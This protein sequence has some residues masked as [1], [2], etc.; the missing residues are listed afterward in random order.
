MTGR[1]LL[2]WRHGRTSWN[3]ERRFQGHADVPLDDHGRTE[4]AAAATMLAAERPD[5]I[6]SSDLTRATQTAQ[7]L[8]ER[9]GL[10]VRLDARLRETGLGGWEG[11]TAPEIELAYPEEWRR[12]RAGETVRRGGGELREEVAA[13]ALAALA[14][15]DAEVVVLVTHGGTAKVLAASLLDL[16][17]RNWRVL[18]PLSNCHWSELRS[19]PYGWRLDRHNVGPVLP[20]HTAGEAPAVDAEEPSV[21]ADD[22]RPVVADDVPDL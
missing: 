2:L 9:T 13:R 8:S 12:W 4:A 7:A 17:A 15:I 1:R 16:P 22:G 10:P 11:L 18:A 19:G 14:D 20:A 5:V 6:V 21:V 3:A